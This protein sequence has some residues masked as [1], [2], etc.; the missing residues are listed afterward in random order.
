[1]PVCRKCNTSFPNHV[2]IKGKQHNLQRRKFCLVCS[3]L[4]AHNCNPTDPAAPRTRKCTDCGTTD[5]RQFYRG[6]CSTCRA[7][8]SKRVRATMQKRLKFARTL[9]GDKCCICGYTLYSS[10]LSIHHLDPGVKDKQFRCH[11]SW[12]ERRLRR[13]LAGCILLC[14]NCHTAVHSREL[15]LPEGIEPPPTH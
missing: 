14:M 11:R 12:S 9:L 1:M 3:P 7:C 4:G 10:A 2:S 8:Q 15:V 6:H 13:E 5:V